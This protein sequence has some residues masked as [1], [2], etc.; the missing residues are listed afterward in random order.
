M[1]TINPEIDAIERL[2]ELIHGL[3]DSELFCI[4]AFV[5][6]EEIESE[7][8]FLKSNVKILNK[9]LDE[10]DPCREER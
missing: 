6:I 10:F 7:M 3:D 5:I 9:Q 2:K 4:E 1:K 8:N